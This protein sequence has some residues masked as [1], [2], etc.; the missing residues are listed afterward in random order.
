MKTRSLLAFFA[1]AGSSIIPAL[2]ADD[3]TA[4]GIL[5]DPYTYENKPVTLDVA[6]VRPVHFQSPLPQLAFFRAMTMDRS[7]RKPSGEIMV[8]VAADQ[9][10]KFA[11][12][13]GTE[14]TRFQSTPLKGTLLASPGREEGRGKVWLIDTTGQAAELI[15]QKKLAISDDGNGGPGGPHKRGPGPRGN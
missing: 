14:F 3:R 2:A 1:I 10:E 13:Y 6:V 11:K 4:S 7:S 5:S 15:Q 12:K 8:V 9:S